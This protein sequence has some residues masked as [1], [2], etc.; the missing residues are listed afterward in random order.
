MYDGSMLPVPVMIVGLVVV[1]VIGGI[2]AYRARK[3]R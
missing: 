1:L 3:N 2:V